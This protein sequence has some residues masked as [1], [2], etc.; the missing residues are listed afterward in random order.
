MVSKDPCTENSAG[1]GSGVLFFMGQESR[2][3]SFPRDWP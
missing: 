1:I 2:I 3:L